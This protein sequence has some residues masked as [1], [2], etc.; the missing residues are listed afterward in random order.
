MGYGTRPNLCG[1]TIRTFTPD[2][3]DECFYIRGDESLSEIISRAKEKW[4]ADI[5]MDD[6]NVSA[7]NIHEDCLDYDLYDRSDYA[8]YL[9]ISIIG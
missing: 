1:G 5:N 3:T 6:I 8:D 9:C 4:G 7:E 2:D